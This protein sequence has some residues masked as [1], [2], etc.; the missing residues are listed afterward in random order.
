MKKAGLTP[1][2]KM[3]VLLGTAA[4]LAHLHEK[5]I[6]HRDIKPENVL[7]DDQMHPKIC[8]FGLAK[9]L[10]RMGDSG[11]FSG[12]WGTP[13]YIAPEILLD[14]PNKNH[15]FGDIYF[16]AMTAW[17]FSLG[18]TVRKPEYDGGRESGSW[19]AAAAG[20]PRDTRSTRHV[21]R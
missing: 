18:S 10:E 14:E 2:Q 16:Y 13:R 15:F 20:W 11:V 3:I 4:A 9:E 6:C 17:S 21:D 7:L 1:T 12:L 5:R 19:R 8:D